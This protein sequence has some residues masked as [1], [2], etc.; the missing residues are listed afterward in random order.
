MELSN[1]TIFFKDKRFKEKSFDNL[2]ECR[3]EAV[4]HFGKNRAVIVNKNLV[5][6]PM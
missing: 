6:L 3:K 4:K 5:K 1:F 2:K